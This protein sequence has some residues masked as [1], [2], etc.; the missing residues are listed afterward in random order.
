[1]AQSEGDV[2]LGAC[3]CVG[4]KFDTREP[5]CSCRE[6]LEATYQGAWGAL[7]FSSPM[8]GEGDHEQEVEQARATRTRA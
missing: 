6:G 4:D 1:M 7:G 3:V 2:Y 5:G 8:K